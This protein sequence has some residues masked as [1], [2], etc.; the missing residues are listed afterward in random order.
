MEKINTNYKQQIWKIEAK[1]FNMRKPWLSSIKS[2]ICFEQIAAEKEKES[3]SRARSISA[4]MP[5]ASVSV[6]IICKAFLGSR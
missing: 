6:D 2:D 5:S 4:G 3:V 1:L